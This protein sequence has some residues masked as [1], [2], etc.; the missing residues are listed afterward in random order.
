MVIALEDALDM[1]FTWN[2]ARHVEEVC[3]AEL[4]E[5]SVG[6]LKEANLSDCNCVDSIIV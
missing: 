3:F 5:E 6:R 1:H 2:E 4:L